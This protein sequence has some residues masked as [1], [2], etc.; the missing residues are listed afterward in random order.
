MMGLGLMHGHGD[1]GHAH[2]DGH[3]HASDHGGHIADG[4]HGHGH[5]DGHGFGDS[6]LHG[7]PLLFSPVNLFSMALAMGATGIFLKD[8]L[9][10]PL[11]WT[12]AFFGGILFTFLLIRPIM[13]L[14]LS[15]ASKPSEGLQGQLAQP[16]EAISNFDESGRGL[17]RVNVD[18]EI[19]QLLATLDPLELERGV[20]VRKGEQVVVAQINEAKGTCVVI[21]ET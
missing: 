21:R 19:K 7:L 12:A 11:I 10:G 14:V 6:I 2:G 8:R 15:F 1:G 13:R 20:T 16:A 17:I 18:G 3:G 5:T 9:T 4:H